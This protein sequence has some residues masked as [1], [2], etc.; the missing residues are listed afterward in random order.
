[1][2]ICRGPCGEV[3]RRAQLSINTG[4]AQVFLSYYEQSNTADSNKSIW[5][6]ITPLLIGPVV[7]DIFLVPDG[8]SIVILSG[9][10]APTQGVLIL[11]EY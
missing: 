5:V 7:S 8:W 6:A 11:T 2:R 10:L 9:A 3:W 4:S 1:M